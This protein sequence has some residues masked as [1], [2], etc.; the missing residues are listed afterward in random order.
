ML[1]EK[2]LLEIISK[3]LELPPKN[4][5]LESNSV[6]IENWDSLGHLSILTSLEKEVKDKIVV[7]RK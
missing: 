3:A 4:I 1:T 6:N 7:T 5:T 2:R